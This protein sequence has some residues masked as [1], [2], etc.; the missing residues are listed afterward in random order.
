M[1][2]GTFKYTTTIEDAL[3]DQTYI[4]EFGGDP[5]AVTITGESAGGGSVMLMDMGKDHHFLMCL[6][7]DDS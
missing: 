1:G 4:R 2:A 3:I 6:I 7:C 5:T